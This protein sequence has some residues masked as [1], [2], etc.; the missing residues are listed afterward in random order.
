MPKNVI[1]VFS[2]G[3]V[4]GGAHAGATLL[5]EQMLGG[6]LSSIQHIGG[7]SSG[8]IIAML[9][10]LNCS[11]EKI[12][13]LYLA[14]DFSKIPDACGILGSGIEFL[15][16]DSL[17][18]GDALRDCIADLIKAAHGNTHLTFRD[19]QKF[20]YKN[21]KVITTMVGEKADGA[22]T[23]IEKEFSADTTPDTEI[24]LAVLASCSIPGLFPAI[25][26]KEISPGKWVEDSL[27][28]QFYD[29]GYLANLPEKLFDKVKY[30]SNPPESA[31]SDQYCYNPDVI[32]FLITTPLNIAEDHEI[33][34]IPPHQPLRTL[35]AL[36]AGAVLGSQ[37]RA[38]ALSKDPLRTILLSN[39]NNAST[40]FN[41]TKEMEMETIRA[42]MDERVQQQLKTLLDK[43]GLQPSDEEKPSAAETFA[44]KRVKFTKPIYTSME[45]I[46]KTDRNTLPTTTSPKDEHCRCVIS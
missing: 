11:A 9:I 41:I 29:G 20:G 22:G 25:R 14:I 23:A 7:S 24:L 17:Y 46:L 38:F 36:T 26:L 35:S 30:L 15:K 27:G 45:D 10:A 33:K 19:L 16:Q 39:L 40:N 13:N 5:L 8:A 21:L 28:F 3:G 2:G 12:K 43:I 42:A 1:P 31:P 18:E 37:Q 32:G 6:S 4:N 44:K 34:P